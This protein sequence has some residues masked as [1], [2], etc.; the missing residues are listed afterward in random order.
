MNK[1]YIYAILSAVFFGT[2]GIF[3]K[4]FYTMGISSI[5]LL[6]LQYI[7]SVAFMII[8]IFFYN[9]KFFILNKNSFKRILVMGLI[10]N[11]GMT[12]FYY[13]SFSYLDVSMVTLLLYTFPAIVFIYKGIFKDYS[14]NPLNILAII[15]TFIGCLL[16]LNIIGV[17]VS[18]NYLGVFYG[19]LGAFFYALMNIYA[20]ERLSQI[21]PL[22]INLYT[23]IFSLVTLILLNRNI[24]YSLIGVNELF[25]IGLFSIMGGILPMIFLFLAIKKIGALKTAIISNLEIPT[26]IILSIF[27]NGEK[28]SSFGVIGIILIVIS[29]IIFN[30]SKE[31]N[32]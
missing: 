4:Y 5:K 19:M 16:S 2:A 12:F 30:K 9:V 8:F 1:G 15:T 27:I 29:V 22:T 25:K 13:K 6:M 10:L 28:I 7:F 3:V 31:C 23:Y 24:G 21:E 26:A 11:P 32:P 20:E 17:G 18:I 14:I